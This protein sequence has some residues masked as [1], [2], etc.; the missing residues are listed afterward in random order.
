MTE[1]I[2]KIWKEKN[3]DHVNFNFSCGGDSMNDTSI[4]IFDKEGELVQDSELETYFDDKTYNNVDFYVNSDGH[5][6]GEFGVVTIEFD[7]DENDFTYSKS[8]SS[9]W[10]E[11]SVNEAEIELTDE[12]VKFVADYVLNINGGEDDIQTNYKKDFIL[13]N[14]QEETLKGLEEKISEFAQDYTPIELNDI[15]GEMNEWHT[16]TT[17]EEGEELKLV[18][19]MLTL[20]ITKSFDVIKE[21]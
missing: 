1:N 20:S 18:D 14:E 2:I 7:E 15:E 3:I 8:S 4:E 6:Q 13:T 11:S 21:D 10:S 9:E 16:Y 12:E 5:Y 19:N 17:N